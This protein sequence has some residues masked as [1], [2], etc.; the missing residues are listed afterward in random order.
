MLKTILTE[1]GYFHIKTSMKGQCCNEYGALFIQK[2][3]NI[4]KSLFVTPLR[5]IF[6]QLQAHYDRTGK[7][8]F[9]NAPIYAS[10]YVEAGKSPSASFLQLIPDNE[11]P[12]DAGEAEFFIRFLDIII[13]S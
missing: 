11:A 5:R 8:N 13:L 3:L 9:T 4:I 1:Q 12:V 10:L 2:A 7:D 6:E